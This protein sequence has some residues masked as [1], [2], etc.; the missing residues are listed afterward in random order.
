MRQ[1][2][3]PGEECRD[4]MRGH[5]GSCISLEQ[6][7][8]SSVEHTI[9]GCRGGVCVLTSCGVE[10]GVASRVAECDRKFD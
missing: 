8:K 1:A 3:N 7:R 9:N 4:L 10:V 6:V 2:L 5:L